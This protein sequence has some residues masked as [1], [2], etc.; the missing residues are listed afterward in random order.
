MK[1]KFIA[2]RWIAQTNRT[3]VF[4]PR[5]MRKR[6]RC[7]TLCIACGAIVRSRSIAPQESILYTGPSCCQA[8][9]RG[10]DL[11]PV[12]IRAGVRASWNSR[13]GNGLAGN[14]VTAPGMARPAK[15]GRVVA[16]G[17]GGPAARPRRHRTGRRGSQQGGKERSQ[18][19]GDFDPLT[20]D[21]RSRGRLRTARRTIQPPLLLRQQRAK[22]PVRRFPSLA[23]PP[24]GG[25]S[26]G[27]G[28]GAD[29]ATGGTGHRPVRASGEVPAG[30]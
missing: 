16:T 11:L 20:R 5:R 15:A 18:P 2:K 21:G 27:A 8:A 12:R 3:R 14:G 6:R 10:G 19:A 13:I 25:P 30:L 17:A 7:K 9:A 24:E 22:E 26:E 4:T 23:H 1:R 28:H 29:R